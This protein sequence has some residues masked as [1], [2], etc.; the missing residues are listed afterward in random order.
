L[1]RVKVQPPLREPGKR[2]PKAS[3]DCGVP[4]QHSKLQPPT[5]DGA[6]QQRLSDRLLPRRNISTAFLILEPPL[7]EVKASGASAA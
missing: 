6:D 1:I 2:W 3:L 7:I 4:T 5:L